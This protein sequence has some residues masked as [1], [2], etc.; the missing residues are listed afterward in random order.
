[1]KT[2]AARG[3][4]AQSLS[5]QISDKIRRF[6]DAKMDVSSILNACLQFKGG[7]AQFS[8]TTRFFE[9][10]E[11]KPWLNVRRVINEIKAATQATEN[12]D[13]LGTKLAEDTRLA[14][15]ALPA[16]TI[17][18]TTRPR[19]IA[20]STASCLPMTRRERHCRYSLKQWVLGDKLIGTRNE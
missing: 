3:A 6:P 11:S 20:S 18:D 15:S 4:I 7:V 10:E 12:L 1:L 19:S 13:K 9:G 5:Q 8:E 2:T 14:G 17:T 16:P